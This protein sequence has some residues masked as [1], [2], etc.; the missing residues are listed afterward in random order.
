MREQMIAAMAKDLKIKKYLTETQAQFETRA[1]YSAIACWMKSTALDR[2]LTSEANKELGVSKR[3]LL[4]TCSRIFHEYLCRF[5]A[6]QAWFLPDT[7]SDDPLAI[8][9]Q[10]LYQSGDLINIGFK[11]NVT[12]S[13]PSTL[14]LTDIL[15]QK[16]GIVF[17]ERVRY[18]GIATIMNER[19]I[20]TAVADPV[21]VASDWFSEFVKAAWWTPGSAEENI[22]YFNPH[23]SVNNF[24]SGWQTNRPDSVLGFTLKRRVINKLSYEYIIE[25]SINGRIYSHRLDPYLQKTH[26]YRR[27]L[28]ALRKMAHNPVVITAGTFH[29]HVHL[30]MR[31]YL[32]DEEYAL[33]ETFAWPHH[34]IEDR[35][36][37]DMDKDVWEYVQMK[38]SC[39]DVEIE[40]TQHG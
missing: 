17:D 24:S 25:K 5:P 2:P 16:T 1:L 4:D 22:E 8:I 15:V 18:S 29:D 20:P 7:N 21:K 31:V 11:T 34:S 36:E 6:S 14:F 28:F 26:E 9:R 13:K 27:I 3:H 32:P 39:L 37:W 10:R 35:L 23:K 19:L 12:L 40:E 30:K 38:L 33:L